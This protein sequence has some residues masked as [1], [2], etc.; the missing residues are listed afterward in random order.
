MSGASGLGNRFSKSLPSVA[1][2]ATGLVAGAS[3]IS[4]GEAKAFGCT[5]GAVGTCDTNVWHDSN[6]VATDKQILFK[7][8]PTPTSTNQ[9][10]EGTIKF[11]WLDINGNGF[12]NK[13]ADWRVDQ[14]HVNVDFT[15]TNLMAGDGQSNFDYILKITDQTPQPWF[16][17]V[18]LGSVTSPTA[19]PGGLVSKQLFY[20]DHNGSTDPSVW[21]KGALITAIMSNTGTAVLDPLHLKEIWVSDTAI[22]NTNGAVDNYQNSYRQ[23]VPGP[24]P[25]LG[26]GAAFGFTRKLRRRVKAFRMA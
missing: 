23:N 6:P 20:V 7:V 22:A 4:G 25:L 3:L 5:F 18:F 9:N 26:A 10:I 13:P 2:A 19:P 16:Y 24:L 11:D 15:P 21:T 14:W 12:W 8:L 17:D 1:L